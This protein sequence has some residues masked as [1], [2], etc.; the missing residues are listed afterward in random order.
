MCYG[1]DAVP[2]G[3]IG[4]S[5]APVLVW[6][7]SDLRIEDNPALAAAAATH[8]PIVA[9]Y[10]LDETSP[11]IRPLG[12]A[13]RWWLHH[14]LKALKGA[15]ERLGVPLVLRR[16]AGLEVVCDVAA[17]FGARAVMW[18]RLYG[19]AERIRDSAI[20]QALRAAGRSAE[21]F[22]A[23]L[24]KEPWELTTSTGGSFKVFSRFWKTALTHG[25]AP[26]RPATIKAQPR[27]SAH[28]D[29]LA[30]WR[31]TPAKPDW[32]K[33]LRAAWTPGEAG[34]KSRLADFL[35][36]GL[37]GYADG[38]NRPGVASTS[39]LSPH[40]AFGEISPRTVFAAASAI[41]AG[42]PRVQRDVE[43]FQAELGWR[44]F[45][46]HLL[47]HAPNLATRNW[48][49]DFDKV[50][51]RDD[52]DAFTAW[53]KGRTGYPI[54]DAGLRELWTTGWMHNRVRMIA[55]SFLIKH[56]LIDWR[57]GERWF[58]DTL[59]DADPANNAASWQW[60]AGS[61]ADAAPYFRIF[62]PVLQGETYDPHGDYVRRWVPE[63]ARLPDAYL[64]KPWQASALALSGAGVRLG[65][66][67]PTPI[68]DHGQARARALGAF[69]VMK[70]DA[71]DAMETA[72]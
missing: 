30:D 15:L 16:G 50:V 11:G 35:S 51:W 58:W 45:S 4:Q 52:P 33:G 25:V 29:Q 42:E 55:A 62:N 57:A 24:L 6:F 70:S 23:T 18:N 48:R 67:Y 13:A 41:S 12:G 10:V 54:V 27:I 22:N 43:K 44:E 37:A 5:Q 17:A 20:K 32:A 69:K 63:L 71:S 59:V 2:A 72:A 14:S 21:S 60:V 39:G 38:R 36:S 26:P 28:S 8:A 56:L 19:E 68:V 53:A 46:Y 47:F 64:H 7:R 61:G 49:R 34:A 65:E 1:E 3:S 9:L 40:L 31:L 66:D